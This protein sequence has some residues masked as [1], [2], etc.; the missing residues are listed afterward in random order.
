LGDLQDCI[1]TVNTSDPAAQGKFSHSAFTY[2]LLVYS[3]VTNPTNTTDKCPPELLG[4]LTSI[5]ILYRT[6]QEN[7]PSTPTSATIQGVTSV[8]C[9]KLSGIPP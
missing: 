3:G 4:V 1:S 5:Y 2:T 9:M 6:E 8:Q 7:P